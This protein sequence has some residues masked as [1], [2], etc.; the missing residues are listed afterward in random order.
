MH[1]LAATALC[2]ASIKIRWRRRG[3]S[4]VALV[5]FDQDCHVAVIPD[6][7]TCSGPQVVTWTGWNASTMDYL[8]L[9]H[10][11]MGL[12]GLSGSF[13]L[14]RGA[15]MLAGSPLLQNRWVRT[16]PHMVDTTLLSSAVVLAAWSSQYPFAQAWL[17]AKVLALAVYIILGMVALKRG[18]T[19]RIRRVA[20]F[21]ALLI[22]SYIV[23]VAIS[24]DPAFFLNGRGGGTVAA[25]DVAR[26]GICRGRGW[27]AVG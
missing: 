19:R 10:L 25:D 4:A 16:L 21:A 2:Q 13:F 11:H 26:G 8:S 6:A 1:G 14:V 3:C 23:G 15:W 24:K 12:A 9:K 20:Y 7:R 17:T 5:R 27:T 22:F 18:R